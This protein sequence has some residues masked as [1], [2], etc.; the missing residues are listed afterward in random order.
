MGFYFV[1]GDV[2]SQYFLNGDV[3]DGERDAEALVYESG[4][5]FVYVP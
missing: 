2:S 1:F 4:V 5:H 3:E